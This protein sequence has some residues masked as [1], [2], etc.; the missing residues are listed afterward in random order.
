MSK[1]VT[2][3]L[4]VIGDEI[5][6]GRT[7]DKNIA[8]IATF[9]EEIG[10]SLAEVRIV[11]D[12]FDEIIPAVN[13][14]RA[15]YDYLFTTGGIGP[16][17][18]DITAEAIAKAFQVSLDQNEAAYA[19]LS[20]HYGE[21][22]FTDARKRM[23]R[24]PHGGL[25]IKNPV[26]L[27]P[28]FQMDNVFTLAGVPKIM[29]SMLEDVRHRLKGGRKIM[30][31]DLTLK[32]GESSLFECLTDLNNRFESVSIGSYPFYGEGRFA[33]QVV[34]RSTID[35]DLEKCFIT[36]MNYVTEHSIPVLEQN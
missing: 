12:E 3:A 35:S 25:L 1:K 19:I 5:L 29:Q 27:A 9:L 7:Q 13:R 18:D 36:L 11:P 8:Y 2:A 15:K 26:S 21:D 30:T 10:I 32:I 22:A 31:K 20:E 14:L 33:V 23:T 24:I 34:M 28:G 6:S 16:T 17:H 4:C